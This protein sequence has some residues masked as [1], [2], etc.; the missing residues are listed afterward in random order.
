MFAYDTSN[1]ECVIYIR[2]SPFAQIQP[3]G[4]VLQLQFYPAVIGMVSRDEGNAVNRSVDCVV[5]SNNW[6]TRV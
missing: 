5:V 2:M 3:I 1:V 6:A 4:A